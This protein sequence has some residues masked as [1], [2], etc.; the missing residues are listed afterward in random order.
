MRLLQIGMESCL[1]ADWY[2]AFNKM[3]AKIW[4]VNKTA[5]NKAQAYVVS[6]CLHAE[7]SL[8]ISD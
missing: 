1:N 4:T 6:S 3:R 8:I 5:Y 7:T 2:C